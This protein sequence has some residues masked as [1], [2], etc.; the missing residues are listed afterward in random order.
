MTH[1]NYFPIFIPSAERLFL[2]VGGGNV[3]WRRI[4]T[5]RR[6]R[7]RIRVVAPAVKA[8]I[9]ALAAQDRLEW[10]ARTFE[11][12]DLEGVT[13]ATAA[14]D[15][16]TVNQQVG[17][18]CRARG[19]PVSVA[20]CPAECDY[21]FPAVAVQGDVVAGISGNGENHHTV[22]KAAARVRTALSQMDEEERME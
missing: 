19:I 5:L 10:R 6:F 17:M 21:F 7:W 22:A 11:P 20:D 14:T 1:P 9:A 8:E 2:V 13:L 16:R 4:Q 12:G 18:L 3:A 15:M